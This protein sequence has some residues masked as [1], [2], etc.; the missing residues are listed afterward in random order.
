MKDKLKYKIYD[1]EKGKE[2]RFDYCPICQKENKKNPCFTV[3]LKTG[4]YFC[5]SKSKGGAI[6]ELKD[7]KNIDFGS[8]VG[9]NSTQKKKKKNFN[10]LFNATAT[11]ISE[12]WIQYFKN[13]SINLGI[14]KFINYFKMNKTDKRLMIPITDDKEVIGIKYRTMNK[15]CK[16]EAGSAT[17]YLLGWARIKNFDELIICEG[18]I[19][20]VS[21]VAVGFEN[22]VSLP[23]G[24]GNLKCIDNQY[25]WI[26][27]FK[28][29]IIATDNDEAGIKA[30]KEIALKLIKM[31][32]KLY[33]IDLGTY[34]D[35]N[36]VLVNSKREDALNLILEAQKINQEETNDFEPF[37]IGKDGY[38]AFVKGKYVR[39]TN[40]FLEIKGYNVD[41]IEGVSIIQGRSTEF[42]AFFSDLSTKDK[43]LK[44]NIG[45]FL[46]SPAKIVDFWNWITEKIPEKFIEI[47]PHFGIIDNVYYHPK[48]RILCDKQDL[49][50]INYDELEP[51]SNEELKWIEENIIYMRSDPLQAL[52]GICWGLG[53]LH[54]ENM[55]YPIL[56]VA[57]TTSIGKTEYVEFISRMLQG[58]KE[59]IKSFTTLSNHQI[60]S[61]S[62]SSNV[63]NWVI[64]EVKI[65]GINQKE[66]AKNLLSTIRAVYD[67]KEVNQGNISNV[68]TKFH[69]KTPLIVSGETELSDLS[70]KNR[71][72][73][74]KLTPKNKGSLEVFNRLKNTNLLEKLGKAAI[75]DRL[76]NGKIEIDKEMLD[77]CLG[78]ITDERKFYNHSC[79]LLGLK[80]LTNLIKIEN[81]L[82]K[83]FL[84]M[85]NT[86]NKDEGIVENFEQLLDL[87][88]ESGYR[89]KDFYVCDSKNHYAR[90]NM[91]YKVI[92]E[93]HKQTNSVLELVD[94]K[95]LKK[96][97]IE[98]GYIIS[99]R[100]SFRFDSNPYYACVFQIKTDFKAEEQNELF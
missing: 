8:A 74:V 58:S 70:V 19:D 10:D 1:G 33:E 66:L 52:L 17:D 22:V 63:T 46:G 32:S 45:F 25:E 16:S 83:D 60:R 82:K 21:F 13:R 93:E 15:E 18:E 54:N 7:Y 98:V 41:Y 62:S 77:E 51:L 31:A 36:E 61:F 48:S 11:N 55:P 99:P 4:I 67:N 12:E 92:A 26:R 49:N 64:D 81:K 9:N 86:Q 42:K 96:Q 90:F 37:I 50:I 14:E 79:I 89:Y 2:A 24:A 20:L 95:T 39:A 6:S 53:R 65:L 5:H 68:L 30:K 28:K 97:L 76:R 73:S 100:I 38:Y 80:A 3:N 75:E 43:I 27:K 35:F 44:N 88:L 94:M 34:N 29:I 78:N 40:F 59:N 57:G 85:L 72:I 84:D 87:V 47:I 56:E 23:F 71:M 69:L 91:L